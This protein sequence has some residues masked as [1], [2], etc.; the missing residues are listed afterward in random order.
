MYVQSFFNTEFLIKFSLILSVLIFSSVNINYVLL[1]RLV[2]YCLLTNVLQVSTNM[3]KKELTNLYNSKVTK[4]QH[5][6]R[7]MSGVLGKIGIKHTGVVATTQNG[8]RYLIHKGLGYG[9]ASSTV[10]TDAKH[11]SSKWTPGLEENSWKT[12]SDLMKDGY[13]DRPYGVFGGRK[14]CWDASRNIMNKSGRRKR[15]C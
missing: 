3:N 12:I 1:E 15:S 14:I 13:V 10:I 8:G 7:P 6:S 11:M 9:K 4:V 5:H 2:F